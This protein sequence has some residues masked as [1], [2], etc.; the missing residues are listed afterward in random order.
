M[1]V[2]SLEAIFRALQEAE[3]RYLVVGGIAV[4]AHGYVR[5]TKDLDLVLDLSSES[6]KRTLTVLQGLGYRPINPVPILDFADP[7]LRRDW[8]ENRNMI[9]FNLVSDL[10]PDIAI[11][12]FAKEPFQFDSEYA[13][14]ET[15]EVA[16]NIWARVVSIS[17][18]IALK[19]VADRDQDRIDINKLE[20]LHPGHEL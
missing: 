16:P 20:K 19:K 7:E 17:T 3:A 14:A 15:K 13:R 11:D 12:I 4:V 5:L 6:L 10:F 1:K 2:A 9:V 18:L 8:T